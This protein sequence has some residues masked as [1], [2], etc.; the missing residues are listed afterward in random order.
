MRT[1]AAYEPSAVTTVP[2]EISVR[3]APPSIRRRS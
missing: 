2:F 1:S 3:I